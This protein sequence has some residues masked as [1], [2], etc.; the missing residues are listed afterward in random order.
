M[1]T[2][3]SFYSP[4]HPSME[5]QVELARQISHSL[6]A[7][8]NS[9]S[10]GQ[11]MYVKRRNR[12]SKW[13]HEAG[14]EKLEAD[15]DS[16]MSFK[17]P[18]MGGQEMQYRAK[19]PLK[20][21]M[22][23]KGQ[24]WDL[25]ALR[26]S[27]ITIDAP[28][29]SPE[30]CSSLVKDLLTPKGKGA[31]L[32]A[33][34]KQ[35]SEK[36]IV[37]E[38]SYKQKTIAAANAAAASA[39]AAAGTIP[40]ATPV[41]VTP[42]PAAANPNR[43]VVQNQ[44]MA[45]VQERF[46]GPRY[47]LLKSPWEAALED[48]NVNAAFQ[49]L[50]P[51][52]PA[53]NAAAPG[54]V[55]TLP[56]QLAAAAA[57]IQSPALTVSPAPVSSLTSVSAIQPKLNMKPLESVPKLLPN[58]K[59]QAAQS[60]AVQLVEPTAAPVEEEKPFVLAP[61]R[62]SSVNLYKPTPKGWANTAPS[63]AVPSELALNQLRINP[64]VKAS[65]MFVCPTASQ[66]PQIVYQPNHDVPEPK[67]LPFEVPVLRSVS[68]SQKLKAE[69]EKQELILPALRP[70]PEKVAEVNATEQE[71]PVNQPLEWQ[72]RPLDSRPNLQ[73]LLQRELSHEAPVPVEQPKQLPPVVRSLPTP[74]PTLT[75]TLTPAPANT[76]RTA[77]DDEEGLRMYY[78]A[79]VAHMS[80]RNKVQ[81]FESS[82]VGSAMTTTTAT[83]ANSSSRSSFSYSSQHPPTPATPPTRPP[84]SRAQPEPVR[85][86]RILKENKQTFAAQ[87]K[88]AGP[89]SQPIDIKPP[90]IQAS[91]SFN[92]FPD[93]QMR[94]KS[95]AKPFADGDSDFNRRSLADFTN[96]NTAP[97]GW[98]AAKDIYRPVTFKMG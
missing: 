72:V 92:S 52:R 47:K 27:G 21:L 36:W 63:E 83:T 58:F 98:A 41:E 46:G 24:I 59:A 25:N 3:S 75:P 13:I 23:P 93:V 45:S 9:L 95:S 16:R 17:I 7:D 97:R 32:F 26:H 78:E 55:A 87:Q 50:W 71:A 31:A 94:H 90:K 86:A 5:E 14:E 42:Q 37:D 53:G 28:P 68:P 39:A 67:P 2:S 10:K 18:N 61:L 38:N 51:G 91:Q 88:P 48:G 81:R 79:H 69:P 76:K 89:H 1:Y 73:A 82:H 29:L 85:P 8:T 66:Q 43:H 64:P 34:R 77:N 49:E 22:N 54:V 56:D 65:E 30:I 12:S 40:A 62:P 6:S 74:T 11:S 20:L 80:V 96:Y 84:V 15:E 35:K 60:P 70:V 4:S 44:S 33:K 57:S 19:S